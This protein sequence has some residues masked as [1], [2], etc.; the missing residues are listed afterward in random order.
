MMKNPV[1]YV[2]T[3]E[4]KNVLKSVEGIGTEATRASIIEE[5][6]KRGLIE[7]FEK[8]IFILQKKELN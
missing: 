1:K 7:E 6:K 2:E 8:S 4:D 5:L 3:K